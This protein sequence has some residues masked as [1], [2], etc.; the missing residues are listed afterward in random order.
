M[1]CKKELDNER[2]FKEQIILII[3]GHVALAIGL[4]LPFSILYFF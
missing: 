3:I 1:I 2:S 4:A